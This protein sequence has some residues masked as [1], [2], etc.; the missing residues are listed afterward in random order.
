ML[1]LLLIE[2]HNI[3]YNLSPVWGV[4]AGCGLGTFSN[5]SLDANMKTKKSKH[6]QPFSIC[7]Y[8]T[9]YNLQIQYTTS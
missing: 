9:F 7:N 6:A 8:E 4:S 1:N 5:L 3:C 2:F